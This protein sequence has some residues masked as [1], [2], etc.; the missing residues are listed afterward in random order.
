MNP[1]FASPV[2]WHLTAWTPDLIKFGGISLPIVQY[3]VDG[4]RRTPPLSLGAYELD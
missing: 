2:D 1:C 4:L 3:D